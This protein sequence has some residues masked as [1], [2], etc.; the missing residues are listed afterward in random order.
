MSTTKPKPKA[1]TKR[2][3]P[4]EIAARNDVYI[5][6]TKLKRTIIRDKK[7]G[8]M[9]DVTPPH[10][11]AQ[12]PKRR[13]KAG[14]PMTMSNSTYPML[15]DHSSVNPKQVGQLNRFLQS[16]GL[17]PAAQPDGR[18]LFETRAQRK[19]ICEARGIGDRNGGYSDPRM[20]L[21]H[22]G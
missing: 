7:T 3:T 17:P 8:K 5:H 2:E 16:K 15:S 14:I 1:K 9:V 21:R 10:I 4:A 20:G 13:V 19:A 18:I 22:K 6:P 12:L 11:K